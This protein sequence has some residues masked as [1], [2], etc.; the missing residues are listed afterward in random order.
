MTD[1]RK[2][3]LDGELVRVLQNIQKI[4]NAKKDIASSY[5]RLIDEDEAKVNRLTDA[6]SSGDDSEIDWLG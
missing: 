1:E 5:K 2:A 3:Q 6:L 4:K